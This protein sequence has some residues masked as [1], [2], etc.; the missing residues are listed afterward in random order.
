MEQILFSVIQTLNG[1]EVKG[2]ANV[3]KIYCSIIALENLIAEIQRASEE[4]AKEI[5]NG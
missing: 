2:K 5:E 1:I 4:E 3:E